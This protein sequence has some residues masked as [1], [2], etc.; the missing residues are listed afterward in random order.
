MAKA[1]KAISN[2]NVCEARFDVAD[3]DGPWLASVGRPELRGS[4]IIYGGSGTGKTTFTLKLCK[5][6]AQFRRVAYDTLEQGLCRSFQTAWERVK[7]EEA[8]KN[9]ILLNREPLEPLRARLA[10]RKSPEVVFIDSITCLVGFNRRGYL[11]L[12]EDFPDKLFVFI[13]HEK[14]KLP[15]PAIAETVRRLSDVKI[16]V[17]GYTAFVTTRYENPSTGEGGADFVIWKKGAAEYW[18]D[19]L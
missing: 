19:K 18:A 5:Y 14:N 12:L 13:S 7:M 15:D 1:T 3:F 9:V 11:E 2:R 17:E 4:W 16:R 6:L 10:K 8:G